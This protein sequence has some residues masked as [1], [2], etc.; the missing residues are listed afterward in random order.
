MLLMAE[1]L[2]LRRDISEQR[3]VYENLAAILEFTMLANRSD[4]RKT[5]GRQEAFEYRRY[6]AEA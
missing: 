1:V 6:L 5:K 4:N 2:P 3:A